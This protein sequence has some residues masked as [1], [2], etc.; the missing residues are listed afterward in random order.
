MVILL[1]MIMETCIGDNDLVIGEED[2]YKVERLE[3]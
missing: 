3:S 2:V 1:K